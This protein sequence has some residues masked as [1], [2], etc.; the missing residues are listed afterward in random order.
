MELG[1]IFLAQV[2]SVWMGGPGVQ[3]SLV[4]SI[5]HRLP[6]LKTPEEDFGLPLPG[7]QGQVPPCL[8]VKSLEKNIFSLPRSQLTYASLG[9][10]QHN[11]LLPS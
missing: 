3:P 2:K 5:C 6:R 1:F 7:L 4:Q 8:S 11:I 9:F 10:S